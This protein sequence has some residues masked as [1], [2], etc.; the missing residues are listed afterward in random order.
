MATFI[1]HICLVETK[2]LK[3]PGFSLT[4][5]NNCKYNEIIY[6]EDEIFITVQKRSV[7]QSAYK[8]YPSS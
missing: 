2:A 1:I 8:L 3:A 7:H 5:Y 6:E 4:K